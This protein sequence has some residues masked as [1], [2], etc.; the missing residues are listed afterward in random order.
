VKFPASGSCRDTAAATQRIGQLRAVEALA[1]DCPIVWAHGIDSCAHA[2]GQACAPVTSWAADQPGTTIGSVCALRPGLLGPLGVSGRLAWPVKVATVAWRA[3][4]G[5]LAGE[6]SG[7]CGEGPG[8]RRR[9]AAMRIVSWN[10]WWR[11]GPWEQRREAIAAMLAEI[12]PDVCGLQEVRASPGENLATDLAGRL[13]LHWCW[14]PAAED[15]SQVGKQVDRTIG[16]RSAAPWFDPPA[17]TWTCPAYE[18]MI[19]DR[20]PVIVPAAGEAGYADGWGRQ[21]AAMAEWQTAR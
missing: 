14:A 2:G 5:R 1:G 7:L 13:G 15:A 9:A 12:G 11:F 8:G 3:D 18:R 6:G 10:L 21:A 20:G 16:P 19:S 17:F 4:A